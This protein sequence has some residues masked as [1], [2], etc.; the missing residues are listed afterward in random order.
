MFS[1]TQKEFIQHLTGQKIE[2]LKGLEIFYENEIIELE[3]DDKYKKEIK[4]FID[5]YE[6]IIN[7]KKPRKTRQKENKLDSYSQARININN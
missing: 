7:K 5:N 1:K 4:K 2:E 3:E 6:A